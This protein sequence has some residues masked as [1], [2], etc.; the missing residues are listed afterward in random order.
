MK[1]FD[2]ARSTITCRNTQ[3]GAVLVEFSLILIAMITLFYGIIA[4]SIVFVT[5]QAVAYA[6]ESGADAVVAVDPADPK[7]NDLATVAAT[8][9]VEDL[10]TF[11]PGGAP[12][13]TV[14]VAI[15]AGN[16]S[17]EV[18]V[19]LKYNFSNW[20]LPVTGL[21]LLPSVLT[22]E[23]LVNTRLAPPAT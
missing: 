13:P 2:T 16:T 10:L 17:R 12:K 15:P 6:A 19:T 9:R 22:G 23:A 5:Q 20:G 7:Y 11:L 14:S 18:T 21:F 4:Y 1:T 8:R 3:T